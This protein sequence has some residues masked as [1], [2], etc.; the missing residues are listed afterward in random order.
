MFAGEYPQQLAHHIE[1]AYAGVYGS[2]PAYS[3]GVAPQPLDQPSYRYVFL[4]FAHVCMFFCAL[5][6]TI[7]KY[8]KTLIDGAVGCKK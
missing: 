1:Q 6:L 3:P 8:K 4:V 2:L 7:Q 5:A